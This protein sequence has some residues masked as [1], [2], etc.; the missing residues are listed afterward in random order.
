MN[1]LNQKHS[2]RQN[3]N[4]LVAIFLQAFMWGSQTFLRE[5]NP[6]DIYVEVGNTLIFT[7]TR[8]L[9]FIGLTQTLPYNPGNRGIYLHDPPRPPVIPP[10][11]TKKKKSK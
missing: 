8:V 10:K 2:I 5:K 6:G 9:V 1:I 4:I 3:R 11:K 7:Y